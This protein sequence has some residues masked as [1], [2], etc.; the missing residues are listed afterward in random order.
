MAEQDI[1]QLVSAL[2]IIHDPRSSNEARQEAY[3]F[4]EQAKLSPEAPSN[5]WALASNANQSAIIRHYGLSLLEHAIRRSWTSYSEQQALAIQGWIVQLAECVTDRDPPYL[6]NKVAYTWVEVAKRM[7]GKTWMNMDEMLFK[8]F[9]GSLVHKELCLN[10]L[11][12]LSDDAFRHL[13]PLEQLA[14]TR[15][16]EIKQAELS[17]ACVQTFTPADILGKRGVHSQENPKFR[18]DY[19]VSLRY[20]EEGW[21]VRLFDLVDFCLD[22][23]VN[24][25]GEVR[26]CAVKTLQT[27]RSVS[28]WQLSDALVRA[29]VVPRLC[30]GLASGCLPVQTVRI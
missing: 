18:Q 10:V 14:A 5:G 9:Q 6:R 23:D 13:D 27:I 28:S 26:S 19:S 24:N 8:L 15:T 22:N 4:L 1:S 16:G 30:R 11:D 12:A 29:A 17:K 20:G 3:H 2:D 7:W 25:N 21:L